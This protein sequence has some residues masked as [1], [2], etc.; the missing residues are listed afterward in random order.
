MKQEILQQFDGYQD[1]MQEI[2]AGRKFGPDYAL[3]K[4]RVAAWI[5]R[6]HPARLTLHV[7]DIREETASTKTLRLVA[8]DRPLPPFQDGQYLALALQFGQVRTGRPYS[9]SSS[10]RNTGYY[11]ITV[12]RVPGGLVSGYLL[13]DI[14]IGDTLVSSGPAGTFVHNPVFHGN[15]LVCIAGG[16]GIA[17]F[18]SMIRETLDC[19]LDRDIVLL[20]GN[21]TAD[22]VIFHAE[23]TRLASHFNNFR[24]VPVLEESG[25]LHPA[26]PCQNGYITRDVLREAVGDLTG[27][28]F[29]LCGPAA[30]YDFCRQEL[31]ALGVPRRRIRQEAYGP[32]THIAQ[33]PGWPEAVTEDATFRVTVNGSAAIPARA[34]ETLLTALERA[35]YAVPSQCRSGECGLCRVRLVSGT[36]YQP[37][38]VL[39][40]AADRRFGYIHSCAAYPLEDLCVEI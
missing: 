30:L 26:W 20:Y 18:M 9:I 17:P 39:L 38:S 19:G 40:R 33:S 13:D 37:P 12:R 24:Y 25:A 3:F 21:R 32:P 7:G 36:V 34:G 23:L 11:D 31:E 35:G 14:R 1:V 5:D 28:M 29:Y 16:S 4:G 2:E 6:Y 10:P 27:R 8:Q 22:D 15:A